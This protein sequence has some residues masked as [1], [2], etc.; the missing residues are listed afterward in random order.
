[1]PRRRDPNFS[2]A[3]DLA[4]LGAESWIVMG[5]RMAKLAGGG[6]AAMFEAQ[7]MVAEKSVAALEAQ[8]AAGLA[9]AQGA[10]HHAV[11]RST[12]AGYRRR[13]RANRR[14]LMPKG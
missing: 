7:R 4:R 13:V 2:H 1:M 9:F 3:L 8:M 5:L 6:P 11:T 10:T 12:V 14:R